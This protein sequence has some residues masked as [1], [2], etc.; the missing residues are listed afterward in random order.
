MRKYKHEVGV[1]ETDN[2][3]LTA[4]VAAAEKKFAEELMNCAKM[5]D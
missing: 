4:N 2:Q 3:V 1:L 5:H